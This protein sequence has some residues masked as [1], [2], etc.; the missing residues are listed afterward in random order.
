MCCAAKFLFFFAEPTWPFLRCHGCE[1][2]NTHHSNALRAYAQASGL[3]Q[4]LP[5]RAWANQA[6]LRAVQPMPAQ[7]TEKV[8]LC[9]QWM[10]AWRFGTLLQARLR[11]VKRAACKAHKTGPAPYDRLAA[12]RSCGRSSVEVQNVPVATSCFL[13]SRSHCTAVSRWDVRQN[14]FAG[15]LPQL[16]CLQVVR[17][18]KTARTITL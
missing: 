13:S 5:M 12:A 14:Q 6:K 10:H 1:S 15:A 3:C 11:T 2:K 4:M 18:G 8:L 17:R 7:A 16:P 9:V